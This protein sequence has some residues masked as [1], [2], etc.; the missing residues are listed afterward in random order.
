MIPL[1]WSCVSQWVYWGYIQKH[2]WEMPYKCSED[3]K[4]ST[5]KKNPPHCGWWLRTAKSLELS[6]QHSDRSTEENLSPAAAYCFYNFGEE[7]CEF[8]NFLSWSFINILNPVGHLLPCRSGY[9]NPEEATTI[10]WGFHISP[11]WIILNYQGIIRRYLLQI[12]WNYL[13]KFRARKHAFKI[14][15]WLPG[16][17]YP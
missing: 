17:L 1:K 5:S 2:G 8:C 10:S 11:V 4:T 3:S 7:P 9:F 13:Q 15:T 6:A 14:G 16:K 12:V